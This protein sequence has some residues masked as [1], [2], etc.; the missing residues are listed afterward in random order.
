MDVYQRTPPAGSNLKTGSHH[1]YRFGGYGSQK[2][3]RPWGLQPGLAFGTA[4]IVIAYAKSD[5]ITG[6]WRQWLTPCRSV[7]PSA[8]SL[9]DSENKSHDNIRS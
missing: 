4:P 9:T 6:G 2:D 1:P 5:P 7:R 3:I 8:H